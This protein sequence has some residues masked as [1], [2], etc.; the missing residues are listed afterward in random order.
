MK[1]RMALMGHH[2]VG[3]AESPVSGPLP[4][5]APASAA[6]CCRGAGVISPAPAPLTNKNGS[7]LSSAVMHWQLLQVAVDVGTVAGLAKCFWR[8]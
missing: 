5:V 7:F 3:G 2:P 6:S 8:L 1:L 4:P